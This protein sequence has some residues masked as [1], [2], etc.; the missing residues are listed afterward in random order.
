[1]DTVIS[2]P[3]CRIAAI[4]DDMVF[5]WFRFECSIVQLG[6]G[7]W[8][9]LLETTKPDLLFVNSAWDGLDTQ[10]HLKIC[11]LELTGDQTLA[12][13]VFWCKQNGVP[14]VFW[15]MEDPYHFDHFIHA[16]KLFDFVFTTDTN[17]IPR[18]IEELGHHNV[19]TLPFAAQPRIHNP[20]RKNGK[21]TGPVAFAGTW[22]KNGHED[23]K[24]DMEIVLKPAF[25][26]GLHI[27]DRMSSYNRSDIFKYPPEYAPYLKRGV[28]YSVMNELY[29][30]YD[31]FLN[32]NTVQNSPTM[33]ACRVLELLACGTSVI[34]G[35]ALGI[36]KMLPGLV[37][38]CRSP[39]DTARNL[40]ILLQNKEIR[41][42]RALLGQREVFAKNTY[43]H[44][45]DSILKKT[46]PGFTFTSE[47]GVSVITCTNRPGTDSR[48]VANYNRQKYPVKE[49]IVINNHSHHDPEAWSA[50]VKEYENVKVF[51][52]DGS[53]TLAECLNFGVA[54]ANY[55][56]VAK[57]DDDNYYAPHYLTDLMHAFKYTDADIVGKRSCYVYFQDT[58]ELAVRNPGNEHHYTN[59]LS[60]G[61]LV[62][63]KK[64]FQD[65]R[66]L[67]NLA[68]G[69]VTRFLKRCV[70]NGLRLFSTDRFNY[71][72]IRRSSGMKHTWNIDH[73]EFLRKCE[74]VLL[75]DDYITHVTL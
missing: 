19:F 65:N 67:G 18:Y 29:K 7:N 47:P 59:M 24:K 57:F 9:Q 6:T 66:F 32:V 69:T 3:G 75:T 41:D 16:A 30:K 40:D 49:L 25:K 14:T 53:K 4:L 2:K 58:K 42:R 63:N 20:I 62:I 71:V 22:Y 43:S 21:K 11:D 61:A 36:E 56:Y 46:K 73:D 45:L 26:Y 34:S 60:G 33:F 10:W 27:Y 37:S 35:Y 23:R 72:Y 68:M 52:F 70:N 51:E 13:V 28:P 50:K 74:A 1:M 15:N 55:N 48:I 44:R 39:E 8:Q 31:V 64:V 12:Q 54:Q 17:C 38:L 5:D